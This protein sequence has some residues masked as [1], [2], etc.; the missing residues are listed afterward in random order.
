MDKCTF[1]TVKRLDTEHWRVRWEQSGK[2]IWS[3][4]PYLANKFRSSVSDGIC[5][6][7]I[8][9]TRTSQDA[10]KS[11]KCCLWILFFFY[12]EIHHGFAT[13][14]INHCVKQ[15]SYLPHFEKQKVL[16][17]TNERK[18]MYFIFILLFYI[19]KYRRKKYAEHYITSHN[20]LFLYFFSFIYLYILY[21]YIQGVS[22]FIPQSAGAYKWK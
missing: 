9:Q 14:Y 2:L 16:M 12:N 22:G 20:N 8:G 10:Q 1:K 6:L 5:T 13:L 7:K 11:A 18:F 15:R 4:I 3:S 21:T 17:H 19:C